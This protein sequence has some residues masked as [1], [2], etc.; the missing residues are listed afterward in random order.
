MVPVCLLSV[1]MVA[2]SS[3][4]V[5]RV[6]RDSDERHAKRWQ[7]SKANKSDVIEIG[8]EAERG[9]VGREG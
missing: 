4:K 5:D 8:S 2:V 9:T 1:M 7:L 6:R 3:E